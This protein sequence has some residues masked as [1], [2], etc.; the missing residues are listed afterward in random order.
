M[1]TLSS[2]VNVLLIK[3]ADSPNAGESQNNYRSTD[4]AY[5]VGPFFQRDA[6]VRL[7][8]TRILL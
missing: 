4:A 8:W 6:I 7:T 3:Q 5:H 1:S 2:F